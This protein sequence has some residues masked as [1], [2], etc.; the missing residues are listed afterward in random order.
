V[1]SG[2]RRQGRMDDQDKQEAT[3]VAEGAEPAGGEPTP[4]RYSIGV[5]KVDNLVYKIDGGVRKIDAG[6]RR[7][8]K[9]IHKV[10][11][12]K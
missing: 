10:T 6:V 11:D 12:K 2:R 5:E 7:I 1:A 4:E 3:A 9:E 8:S